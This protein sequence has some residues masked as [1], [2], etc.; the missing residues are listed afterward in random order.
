VAGE[1]P[2]RV[3]RIPAFDIELASAHP[4]FLAAF[5]ET[6]IPILQYEPTETTGP[7]PITYEPPCF[8]IEVRTESGEFGRVI[9]RLCCAKRESPAMSSRY[10]TSAYS[11]PFHGPARLTGTNQPNT[12][13]LMSGAHVVKEHAAERRGQQGEKKRVTRCGGQSPVPKHP[14]GAGRGEPGTLL[15]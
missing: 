6:V 2:Y 3:D 7:F 8:S 4:A 10:L 11:D 1:R 15:R 9:P 13:S 12:P 5:F 14:E